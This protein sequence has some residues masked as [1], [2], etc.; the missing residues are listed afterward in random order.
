MKTPLITLHKEGLERL[1]LLF[2]SQASVVME[3]DGEVETE[4]NWEAPD[5]PTE[6]PLALTVFVAVEE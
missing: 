5:G 2:A 3:D 6:T 1:A 4:W